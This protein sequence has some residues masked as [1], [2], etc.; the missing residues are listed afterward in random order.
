MDNVT[1]SFSDLFEVEATLYS[2]DELPHLQTDGGPKPD[3][4]HGI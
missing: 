2:T 1:R 3:T 4:G